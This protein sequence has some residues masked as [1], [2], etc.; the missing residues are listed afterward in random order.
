MKLDEPAPTGEVNTHDAATAFDKVLTYAGASL[1]RDN[2]DERYETEARNGTA[3]Y[4]GSVT[5]KPGRI[6]LVS[7]VNGYT[8]ADFGTGSREA[9]YDTDN[10]GIPDAWETA[11]GLN[12]N[13]AD[14]AKS[15]TLDSRGYYTN[16]EVFLNS[17]VQ[18][19]MLS[20]NADSDG[21]VRDYY[22]AYTKEDGTAVPAVNGD[23]SAILPLTP[24]LSPLSTEY[25]DL[26]GRRQSQPRGICIQVQRFSDGSTQTKKVIL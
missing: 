15:T 16:L 11:N 20:G 8:E 12:P 13:D 14:D 23:E 2:V 22:P 21:A 6:D 25:Y 5:G 3:T 1:V 7:D 18:D 4:T 9:G 19:I 10:D 17:L 24:H 26:Q